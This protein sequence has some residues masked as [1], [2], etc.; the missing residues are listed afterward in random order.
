MQDSFLDK[1]NSDS[2]SPK[3]FFLFEPIASF[4]FDAV[5]SNTYQYFIFLQFTEGYAIFDAMEKLMVR[6]I[7]D[8]WIP[9]FVFA[10]SV[11]LVICWI[12]IDFIGSGFSRAII[13]LAERVKSNVKNIQKLRKLKQQNSD[14]GT[15][16]QMANL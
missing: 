15:K 10:N 5:V 8:F 11:Y 1:N 14:S 16:A 9:Y 12:L 2:P 3:V 7:R 13:E 4:G 6:H